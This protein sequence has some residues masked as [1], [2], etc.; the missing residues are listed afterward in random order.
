MYLWVFRFLI[1]HEEQER[2]IKG[3]YAGVGIAHKS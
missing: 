2:K 1:M 3:L